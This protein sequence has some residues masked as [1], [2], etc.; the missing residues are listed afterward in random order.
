MRTDTTPLPAAFGVWQFQ[1]TGESAGVS[2]DLASSA[3]VP[4]WRS[5]LPANLD[6]AS[7]Q[8]ADNE[9]QTRASLAALAAIPGRIEVLVQQ[10]QRAG[11][12]EVSFDAITMPEPEAELLD[13]VGTINRP[14]A[15]LSF[16]VGGEQQN[17]IEM[18][19]AQFED[20]MQRL[21]RLV[22]H[23]AWVE[24]EV[25]GQLLGR[26][27]V[28]WTGDLDTNW[29]S[30]LKADIYRLHQRDLVQALATRNLALHAITLTVQSAIK[31][32]VLLATPGGTLL[33]LP[34]AWK[35][36]KQILADVQKYKQVS[37]VQI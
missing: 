34:L 2:F 12:G 21:L 9:A 16:A 7:G 37:Q 26:S 31:L 19:F 10:A 17:K 15:G 24:T 13:L 18:A 25:G 14:A 11:A 36:I 29:K 8:L 33:A 30:G 23:F 22:A 1:P 32:S 35:F 28:S 27:V 4:L 20:D 5:V 3:G 6:Q